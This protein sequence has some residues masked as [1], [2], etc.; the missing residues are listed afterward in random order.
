[1]NGAEQD[2]VPAWLVCEDMLTRTKDELILEAIDILR[3]EMAEGRIDIRG[4]VAAMP[5]KGKELEQDLFV[6]SNLI[7]RAGEIRERYAEYAK[8]EGK[9]GI[10]DPDVVLRGEELR[11]FLLSVNAIDLLM[12]LSRVFG[13]WAD[14]V[15]NYS[16]L[17]NLIDVM[18]KSAGLDGDR[19]EALGFV[20]SSKVFADSKALSDEE[21]RLLKETLGSTGGGSTGG[22][23]TGHLH[24]YGNARKA[25]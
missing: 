8:R 9:G 10:S 3:K 6:I 2:S 20:V 5:E 25:R 19:L 24:D 21:M 7:G 1:M 14:D 12:R 16:L 13:M 4:Y 11:K 17:N 23:S 22:G 15:G 18:V